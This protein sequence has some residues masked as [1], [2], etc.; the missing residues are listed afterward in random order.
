MQKFG[1]R[2]QLLID[3]RNNRYREQSGKSGIRF[4]LQR[5]L[6]CSMSHLTFLCG[7]S[8][9]TWQ[10]Q[11]ALYDADC[12]SLCWILFSVT[13]RPW[14]GQIVGLIYLP[15]NAIMQSLLMVLRYVE[16]VL[17]LKIKRELKFIRVINYIVW[18]IR[19]YY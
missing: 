8:R 16:S 3:C 5:D 18:F 14:F 19:L 6:W 2:W 9:E 13:W 1:K 12:S 15:L 11:L 10:K 7:W 4:L 17:L